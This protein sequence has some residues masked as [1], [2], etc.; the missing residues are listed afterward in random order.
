MNAVRDR[1]RSSPA[2]CNLSAPNADTAINI[3]GTPPPALMTEL[4]LTIA[5]NPP[6][7][8]LTQGAVAQNQ[9]LDITIS[10][11]PFTVTFGTTPP[12]V[13]TLA[14]LQARLAVLPAAQ[15]TAT[16]TGGNMT[17]TAANMG[18]TDTIVITGTA[19]RGSLRHSDHDRLFVGRHRARQRPDDVPRFVGR[20]RRHHGL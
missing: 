9:T 15:G 2:G 5:N 7:N 14:E 4:G 10:G 19:S 3:G 8:L 12:E 11:V 13:S 16:M 20:R 6:T 1:P 18:P 17:I